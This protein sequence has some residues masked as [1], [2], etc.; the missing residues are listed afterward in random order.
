MGVIELPDHL[1]LPSLQADDPADNPRHC[2][3]AY[4]AAIYGRVAKSQYIRKNSNLLSPH[5]E[6]AE[7][8]VGGPSSPRAKRFVIAFV[9]DAGRSFNVETGSGSVRYHVQ[10]AS[11]VGRPMSVT[12]WLVQFPCRN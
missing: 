6:Y 8:S 9:V 10:H 1:R 11:F 7:M 4:A 3:G 2:D 5:S 12:A